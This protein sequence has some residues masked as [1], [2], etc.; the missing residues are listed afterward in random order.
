VSGF[1]GTP[2]EIITM[3]TDEEIFAYLALKRVQEEVYLHIGT[4]PNT[5]HRIEGYSSRDKAILERFTAKKPGT[6]SNTSKV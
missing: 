1:L 6:E 4:Y 5:S 3:T 2:I